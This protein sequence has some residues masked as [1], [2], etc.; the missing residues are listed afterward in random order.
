M[1]IGGQPAGSIDDLL[2][3][4]QAARGGTLELGVVRGAEERTVQVSLA[5]DETA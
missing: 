3:A 2:D 4:V 5:Q 1:T